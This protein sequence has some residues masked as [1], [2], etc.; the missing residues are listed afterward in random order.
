MTL[1]RALPRALLLAAAS[2]LTVQAVPALTDLGTLGGTYSSMDSYYGN[3]KLASY[4]GNFL[5][6]NS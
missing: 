6:G 4:N 2:V 3:S 1:P 5:V